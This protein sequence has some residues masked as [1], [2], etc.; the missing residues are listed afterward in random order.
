MPS[1][2][3]SSNPSNESARAVSVLFTRCVASQTVVSTRSKK[4]PPPN[5]GQAGSP[6]CQIARQRPKRGAHSGIDPLS[7]GA[8]VP[9]GIFRRGRRF[10][11]HRDGVGR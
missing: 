4:Y 8:G 7:A 2:S 10:S 11:M 3:A 6:Q 1:S 9:L 5:Q